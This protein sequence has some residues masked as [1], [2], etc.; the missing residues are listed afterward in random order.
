[1][2]VALI[3]L[4]EAISPQL[5]QF[6]KLGQLSRVA[7]ARGGGGIMVILEEREGKNKELRDQLGAMQGHIEGL[8]TRKR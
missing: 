7:L 8:K 1:M 5:S 4:V 6:R 3:D 2:Q